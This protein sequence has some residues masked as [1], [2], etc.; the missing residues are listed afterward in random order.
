[1]R[2]PGVKGGSLLH[3]R[4]VNA[5]TPTFISFVRHGQSVS[6][7]ARRWEGH[8]DSP[9]TQLGKRQ[10]SLL[11]QRLRRGRFTHVLTSDLKRAAETARATG[12]PCETH[13]ALREIDVGRW[14]GLTREELAARYPEEV[15]AIANGQDIPRGGGESFAAFSA[16]VGSAIGALRA[17][18]APGD[19]AL[20][21]CH[22]AF[23]AT[24]LAGVLGLGNPLRW[25]LAHVSNT[26]LTGISFT[27][28]GARLHVFNDTLHLFPLGEWP[29]YPDTSGMVGLVCDGLEG[30]C[31]GAFTARYDAIEHLSALG[32]SALGEAH[33]ALLT[34]RLGE[35]HQRY[36][37]H[38]VALAAQA[39]SIQAWAER[40]LWPADRGE[41]TLVAPIAGS[42][43]HVARAGERVLLLD[44]GVSALPRA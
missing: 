21:V 38:R 44:Y 33:A 4:G 5:E 7:L 23:I 17:R 19:H 1:V 37:A 16:R 29:R 31:F 28:A 6:N 20:V 26:S 43:C 41:G 27:S 14:G 9:L 22:G 42:I 32:A 24:A 8:G 15:E 10:A 18:L 36:P 34:A 11:G 40:M 12:F 39:G 30:D 25:A 13:A 35:L 2:A 3:H